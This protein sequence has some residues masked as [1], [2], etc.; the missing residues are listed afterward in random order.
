MLLSMDSRKVIL[1]RSESVQKTLKT[2]SPRERNSLVLKNGPVDT[3]LEKK[4]IYVL[5]HTLTGLLVA[6]TPAK[7]IHGKTA[8]ESV[9][10]ATG[11]AGCR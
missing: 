7:K 9:F 6:N 3:D 1:H 4:K 5:F 11:K 2:S 8:S 10:G